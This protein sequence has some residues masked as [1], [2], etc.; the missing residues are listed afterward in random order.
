M[1]TFD[2]WFDY[3]VRNGEFY[4]VLPNSPN[5]SSVWLA[6]IKGFVCEV[7]WMKTGWNEFSKV[8]ETYKID[9]NGDCQDVIMFCGE[10]DKNKSFFSRPVH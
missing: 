10:R 7:Y 5:D 8:I 1:S 2:Y 6:N 3:V 4:P 9:E